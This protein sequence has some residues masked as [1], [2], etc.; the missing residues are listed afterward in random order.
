VNRDPSQQM[1]VRVAAAQAT[2]DRFK[3]R[4]F[5]WGKYDCARLAAYHARKMGYRPSL[6]KAGPYASAGSARAALK[7]LGFS[8][9]IEAVDGMGFE[10]IPPAAA[11]V[12][13]LV[14]MPAVDAL[15]A[16]AVVLGN[17]RVLGYHADA[18]GAAVLQPNEIDVAWRIKP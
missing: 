1:V 16:I 18:V 3:D 6:S 14:A 17:G 4:P 9:I 8:S 5:A 12:G 11:M 15:G 10:R 13:D 2:L 7:R